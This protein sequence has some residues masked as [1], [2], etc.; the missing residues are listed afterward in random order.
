M[1]LVSLSMELEEIVKRFPNRIPKAVG[2]EILNYANITQTNGDNYTVNTLK[3]E[4]VELLKVNKRK[5]ENALGINFD[6]YLQEI[7][8]RETYISDKIAEIDDVVD[9]SNKYENEFFETYADQ[10][11]VITKEDVYTVDEAANILSNEDIINDLDDDRLK[12]IENIGLG[13]IRR[14]MVRYIGKRSV[15]DMNPTSTKS[16]LSYRFDRDIWVEVKDVDFPFFYKQVRNAIIAGND[17]FWQIKV[18]TLS[19]KFLNFFRK[20]ALL[21]KNKKPT[22]LSEV[23]HL[24]VDR[25][26]RLR[27][28]EIT[29]IYE[30]LALPK[31]RLIE[32][33][34]VNRTIA[35]E[36]LEDARRSKI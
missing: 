1:S 9:E 35:T 7:K 5:I 14:W 27:N 8:N 29:S 30:L 2:L 11:D 18:E 33:T 26:R 36:I 34:G 3:K 28:Y 15:V 22:K 12:D 19:G 24:N 23:Q 32:I 31:E 13:V 21:I 6:D 10:I 4:I 20:T 25:L 16:K 17:P